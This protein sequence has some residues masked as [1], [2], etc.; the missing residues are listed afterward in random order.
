MSQRKLKKY[1]TS[2]HRRPNLTWRS[3]HRCRYQSRSLIC[4]LNWRDSGWHFILLYLKKPSNFQ[5]FPNSEFIDLKKLPVKGMHRMLG[6]DP[7]IP[8]A[9]WWM[10]LQVVLCLVLWVHQFRETTSPYN[11]PVISRNVAIISTRELISLKTI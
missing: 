7:S 8:Q 10:P 5:G 3:C 11:K 6:L 1:I 2:C 9:H 4:R